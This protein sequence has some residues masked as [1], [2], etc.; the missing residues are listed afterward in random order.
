MKRSWSEWSSE[1]DVV[2]LE[3]LDIAVLL[4]SDAACFARG[5]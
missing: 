3:L 5:Q 4:L 2:A 1:L